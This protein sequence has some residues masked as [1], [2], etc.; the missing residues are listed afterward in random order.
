MRRGLLR[1]EKTNMCVTATL[2]NLLVFFPIT[3][4]GKSP[5]RLR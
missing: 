1:V 2:S 3:D 4:Q 5:E